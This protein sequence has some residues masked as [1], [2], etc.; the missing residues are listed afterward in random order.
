M[1]ILLD[2]HAAMWFFQDDKRLSESATQAIFNLE[3]IIWISRASL[4]EIA[5]KLSSGKLVTHAHKT[6]IINK[7]FYCVRY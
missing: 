2:T 5:I 3:N 7:L 6:L 1:D 4:W